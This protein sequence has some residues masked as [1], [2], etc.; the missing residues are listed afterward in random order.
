MSEYD[1]GYALDIDP[2]DYDFECFHDDAEVVDTRVYEDHAVATVIC[3]SCGEEWVDLL[4][5]EHDPGLADEIDDDD[6]AP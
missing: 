3:P 6:L 1:W 4:D 5:P 2:E